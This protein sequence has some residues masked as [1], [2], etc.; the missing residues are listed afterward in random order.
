MSSLLSQLIDL[1]NSASTLPEKRKWVRL[2]N[3]SGLLSLLG[4]FV[5][6][7]VFVFIGVYDLA[8]LAFLVALAQIGILLLNH[9]RIYQPNWLTYQFFNCFFIFYYSSIIGEQVPVFWFY[10]IVL[11]TSTIYSFGRRYRWAKRVLVLYVVG[12]IVADLIFHLKPFGSYLLPPEYYE[13]FGFLEPAVCFGLLMLFIYYFFV[14]SQISSKELAGQASTLEMKNKELERLNHELDKLIYHAWHDLRAPI[15]SAMGL[16]N[17]ARDETDMV[18]VQQY[19]NLQDKSLK[20][21]DKLI[22]DLLDYKRNREVAI[23]TQA[24][25]FEEI[26]E[27]VLQNC[28]TEDG[29]IGVDFE[30]IVDQNGKFL[31]DQSRIDMILK[32]LISNAIRYSKPEEL[33]PQI[34]VEIISLGDHAKISVQDHGIGIREDLHDRIFE[35]FYRASNQSEGTGLGLYIVN[36]TARKLGGEVKLNSELGEGSTFEVSIPNQA[37]TDH[38]VKYRT[39]ALAL[40]ALPEFA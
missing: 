25:D 9:H 18:V 10:L 35:M 26:V 3:I 7:L 29:A 17:L 11:K 8:S 15:A 1:G 6:G 28:K 38:L 23:K 39:E 33:K 24:V 13:F 40:P 16:I 19:L 5:H 32:N 37:P 14:Q 22:R 20:K 12:L 4:F 30:V 31:S 36:E 27:S 21:L 34:K 2:S